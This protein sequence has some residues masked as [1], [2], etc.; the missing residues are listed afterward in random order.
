MKNAKLLLF[1]TIFY[2]L[3]SCS[4]DEN[5]NTIDDTNTNGFNATFS[6]ELSVGESTNGTFGNITVSESGNFQLFSHSGIITGN[7]ELN[8]NSYNLTDLTGTGVFEHASFDE[9]VVNLTS[10]Q[11]EIIGINS[12]GVSMNLNGPFLISLEE[13]NQNWRDARDWSSVL[14][15]HDEICFARITVRAPTISAQRY[16][17]LGPYWMEN[18]LCNELYDDFWVSTYHDVD[19]GYIIQNEDNWTLDYYPASGQYPALDMDK[20]HWFI[21]PKNTEYEYDVDWGN[22]YEYSGTF[23]SPD[24]GGKM[25]ICVENPLADCDQGGITDCGSY[26]ELISENFSIDYASSNVEEG[27]YGGFNFFGD[28]RDNH[29]FG[30]FAYGNV[31]GG[32]G[33]H[34]YANYFGDELLDEGIYELGPNSDW[35]L[36][37]QITDQQGFYN[38]VQY[39]SVEVLK[40]DYCTA[41]S[42]GIGYE[43]KFSNVRLAKGTQFYITFSGSAIGYQRSF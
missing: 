14:F 12:D 3:I 34:L 37:V 24:G 2:I 26:G 8:Q 43:I 7:A 10:S 11:L 33:S 17:N 39:G 29:A 30:P 1:F 6:G 19:G 38:S 23:T 35:F 31:G 15:T 4:S 9:G 32:K 5:S 21:L 42:G 16:E 13:F 40:I 41:P 22:G 18:G 28:Y 25:A 27:E 36:I 20:V